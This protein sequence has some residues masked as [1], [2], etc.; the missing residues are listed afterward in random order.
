MDPKRYFLQDDGLFPNSPLPVLHFERALHLPVFFSA[1]HVKRLLHRHGWG[2][3]WRGGIF[4][5]HHY[6]STAH[7]VLAIIEGRTDLQIGGHSGVVLTIR[8]TDVVVIPAG[9]AHKNLGAERDVDVIGG[10]ADNRKFD[11]NYGAP[12]ERPGALKNIALLPL[13]DKDPVTGEQLHWGH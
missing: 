13:P 9:V 3:N 8:K 1:L 12:S 10:Y 6:H 11:L 7:E 4:T 2:N 5:Y